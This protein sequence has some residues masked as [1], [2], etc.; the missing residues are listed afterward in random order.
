MKTS[1]LVAIDYHDIPYYG[2]RNDCNVLGSKHQ[3]GTNWCHQYATLEIVVGAH[4]LTLAVK[5]LSED[6]KE[7]AIVIR[8]LICEAKTYVTID[9]ILLDRAF[10]AIECIRTLKQQRLKF[11]MPVP[12]NKNIK[13]F[14]TGKHSSPCATFSRP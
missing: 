4:R 8:Q 6:E 14:C 9:A 2:N 13:T 11:I 10:Y 5:K 1:A 12:R 3:R 7:K